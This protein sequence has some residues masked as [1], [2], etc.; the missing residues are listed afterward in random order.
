[1][2]SSDCPAAASKDIAFVILLAGPGVKGGELV[3]EQVSALLQATGAPQP[4]IE[5]AMRLQGEV[6]A[7]LA[8]DKSDEEARTAVVKLVDPSGTGGPA[9]RAQLDTVLTPWFRGFLTHDP[10]IA[11]RSVKVPVLALFAE[12]DLQVPPASNEK[13]MAAALTKNKKAQIEVMGGLNHLVHTADTG[14]PTEYGAI[15]ETIAPGWRLPR[16]PPT[17]SPAAKTSA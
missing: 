8:P 9:V 6:V 17:R 5:E 14:M 10:A 7:A 13:A 4:A 2:A 15:T 11:L 1:M 12:K 3:V 16:S